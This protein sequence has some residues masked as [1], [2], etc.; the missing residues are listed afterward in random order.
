MRARQNHLFEKFRNNTK[1]LTSELIN[2]ILSAWNFHVRVK[3][4][5]ALSESDRPRDGEEESAWLRL[6]ER[7]QDK[8]WK[9]ECLKRDEKFD[10]HF[11]SA[12]R[13]YQALTQRFN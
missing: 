13:L 9:Q 10:M 6:T 5:R 11:S 3:I 8:T 1:F 7:V 2:H 4:G 12:V